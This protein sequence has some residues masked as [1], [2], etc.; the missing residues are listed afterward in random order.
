[1]N[2]HSII[3]PE[4]LRQELQW[5]RVMMGKRSVTWFCGPKGWFGDSWVRGREDRAGTEM[6]YVIALQKHPPWRIKGVSGRG[7]MVLWC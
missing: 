6:V 7:A 1:M 4:I 2:Q 5:S 3:A